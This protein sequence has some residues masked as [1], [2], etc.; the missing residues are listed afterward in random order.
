MKLKIKTINLLP[1]CILLIGIFHSE[2]IYSKKLCEESF[3]DR[4]IRD[5]F[6]IRANF[7]KYRFLDGYIRFSEDE[8]GGDMKKAVMRVAHAL[9]K[10]FKKL[11]WPQF[12]GTVQKFYEVR[13]EILNPDGSIKEKYK[14]MEGCVLASEKWFNG[15]MSETFSNV[16]SAVGRRNFNR[17]GWNHF[18]GT[19]RE[20]K[21]IKETLLTE[22]GSIKE[23]YKT[24][25]GYERF[26]YERFKEDVVIKVDVIKEDSAVKEAMDRV[27]VNVLAV[28][29]KNL[30]TELGWRAFNGT[31]QEYR[32][33]KARIFNKDGSVNLEYKDMN[34]CARLAKEVFFGNMSKTFNNV[35]SMLGQIDPL[36]WVMFPGT[37]QQFYALQADVKQYYPRYYRRLTGQR[38]VAKKIF[39]RNTKKAYDILSKFGEIFGLNGEEFFRLGWVRR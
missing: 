8:F 38:R 24:M 31:L 22:N 37:S 36:N 7:Q 35:L 9:G 39:S 1:V 32:A 29:G 12:Y 17:L 4:K 11:E 5:F 27:F 26:T 16:L 18:D 2:K 28:L 21:Y 13:K 33:L 20:Y 25:E 14:T 30:F 3:L 6:S 23:K 15:N 10:E 19:V 34:G